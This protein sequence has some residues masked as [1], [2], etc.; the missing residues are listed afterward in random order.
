[1]KTRF[2]DL[3][4]P[5]H[6]ADFG[7]EG[8]PIVLLHGLG[9]SHTG[10]MPV[11]PGLARR[12]RVIAP[13]LIGFGRTPLDGRRST[14]Q[15]NV[16][17]VSRLLDRELAGEGPVTVVGNSMGGM[18]S[19]MLAAARPDPTENHEEHEAARRKVD[20]SFSPLAMP[21]LSGP[22]SIAVR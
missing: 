20:I 10:W 4:G 5:V 19:V 9:A 12:G 11:G 7:G 2:I 13:D 17:L 21:M 14:I 16:D 15:A 18:V 8:P 3:G 6:V 22:G 1:M